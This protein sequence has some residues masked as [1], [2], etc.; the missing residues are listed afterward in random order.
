MS[1]FY[2][3][4]SVLEYQV[5]EHSVKNKLKEIVDLI[6]YLKK[7]HCQMFVYSSIWN[8]PILGSTLRTILHRMT[9]REEAKLIVI[10][11]V[12]TGPFYYESLL[13]RKLDFNPSVA[14]SLFVYKLLT[15]CFNDKHPLVLSLSEEKDMIERSYEIAENHIF[16][17]VDNYIGGETLPEYFNTAENPTDINNVFEILNQKRSNIIILDKARKSAKQ[18]NFQGR[19]SEVLRGICAL[20]DI[21]LKL[22]QEDVPDEIRTKIFL[23]ETGLEIS[24]ES[25]ATL[26]IRRYRTE[27]EFIVPALGGKK[28]FDWHM[29]IGNSIRVHYYLDRENGVVY[30]G[31]CG[32]HLGTSSYNS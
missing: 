6:N 11:I 26:K 25:D 20:A 1:V 3:N 14:D 24:R 9:N 16:H 27:R 21:E 4:H 30:I 19:F 13:S 28:L 5:N 8:T 18:H 22:L 32:R 12:N 2:L 15:I 10:S 29:K 17:K 7:E 23:D 31:H